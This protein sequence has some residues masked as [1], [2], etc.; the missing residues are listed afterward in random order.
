MVEIR[1]VKTQKEKH[2]F[3][4]FVLDL[5]KNNPYFCP[6]IYS[7]EMMMFSNKN[8]YNDQSE[9]IYFLAYKDNKVVGRIQG[10]LQKASNLKRNEKRIR[11]TRFD[12]IDDQEVAD[13]LFEAVENWGRE[14]GMDTIC[15]PL[16][17]SDLDRE[18]LLIEG[19]DKISTFVEEYNYDYY[20]KLIENNGYKKEADWLEFKLKAPLEYSDR[21]MK[22]SSMM[23]KRFNL[24]VVDMNKKKELIHKYKD[25]FF[26]IIDETYGEL[27]QTVPFTDVMKDQVVNN[28]MKIIK[29][30][31]VILICDEDENVVCFGICFPLITKALQKSGGHM[32]LPCLLKIMK[33][34]RKPKVLEL[35]LIGVVPE[36]ANMAVSSNILARLLVYMKKNNIKYAETNL[37]LEENT[38][39]INEWKK[40]DHE[41][42]KRR[43]AFVKK[44]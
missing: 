35:G 31:L 33:T 41:Q 20:Q 27:Y 44:L 22:I 21:I 1:E 6:P 36:Y 29:K 30:D 7:D 2:Q 34:I 24:H 43:R 14:K 32:T 18:G 15:G 8:I 28:F 23:L 4:D 9:S 13:K 25:K 17:Y 38:K 16:G 39:I 5:Y 26:K 3:L 42:H 11:F 19:F 37:N 40:F 10:I 12:C